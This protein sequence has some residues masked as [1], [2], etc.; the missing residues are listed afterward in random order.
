MEKEVLYQVTERFMDAVYQDVGLAQLVELAAEV[1][2]NPVYIVDVSDRIITTCAQMKTADTYMR[3]MVEFG[4]L[5]D[6]ET[7]K[8]QQTNLKKEIFLASGPFTRLRPSDNTKFILAPIRMQGELVAY[9]CCMELNRPIGAG[10][11]GLM[12]VIN[13]AFSIELQKSRIFQDNQG[14]KLGY[15]LLQAVTAENDQM[16]ADLAHFPN[17]QPKA[18]SYLFVIPFERH[19]GVERRSNIL[20]H[21]F[22]EAFLG[23]IVA[24]NEEGIIVL[25]TQCDPFQ[26]GTAKHDRIQELLRLHELQAG[27]SYQI[28]GLADCRKAYQEA[29]KAVE[30]AQRL[31]K[32]A[33]IAY[34]GDYFFY[35]MLETCQ[36]QIPLERYQHPGILRLLE[37]D[38]EKQTE[39]YHTW[40]VYLRNVQNVP[41]T[42]AELNIHRNTLYYRLSKCEQVLGESLD[43]IDTIMRV[44]ITMKVHNWLEHTGQGG[45]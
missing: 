39:Y 28:T 4:Y 12:E 41:A 37:S 29:R 13:K 16:A 9:S 38:R 24:L 36:G 26:P 43:E 19:Q 34:Y 21:V 30:I 42:T 23:D 22:R 17:W 11:E 10:D 2:G 18:Y 20:L 8:I 5:S 1:M 14:T 40:E 15:R 7:A 6:E 35:H 25:L 44:L 3:M 32:E 33:P 31:H 45:A 27:C